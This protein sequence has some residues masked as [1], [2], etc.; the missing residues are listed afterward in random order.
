[1]SIRNGPMALG[2]MAALGL[3]ACGGGGGGATSSG[4]PQGQPPSSSGA[5]SQTAARSYQLGSAAGSYDL[6]PLGGFSGSLG[7]PATTVPANTRL[8]LTSSFQAPAGAAILQGKG[9]RPQDTGTL[10]VYF[11]TTIRLSSTVTFP[12]LPGFSVTLPATVNPTGLQFFY[13]ISN[14]TPTNGAEAQFRTEG[15]ATLSGQ[16][17]T[18]AP[19]T[20]PLTLQAGQP[21][22]IAFYAISAIAATPTPAPPGAASS[23]TES[24]LYSFRGGADGAGPLAALILDRQDRLYG[25]TYSG[26]SQQCGTVF[27]LTPSAPGRTAWTESVLHDFKAVPDG[28]NPAAGLFADASGGLYGTTKNGGAYG[29]PQ[30]GAAGGSGSV[31][32]LT[33]GNG[34]WSESVLFNFP[35]G[36]GGQGENCCGWAPSAGLIGNRRGDLYSTTQYGGAPGFEGGW[37][38]VFELAPPARG[39]SD[40]TQSVLYAFSGSIGDDG[41]PQAALVL[42]GSG[43]L[44]GTTAGAG[45]P[46]TVFELTPLPGNAGWSKSVIHAFTGGADGAGPLAGLI[47]DGR[48][49]LCGTTQNGGA[50]G[51]GSVFALTTGN[52]GWSESVLYSF[53]AGADGA[54]PV[55]GL[56]LDRRGTLYGTT[57]GGG[58]HS[59]GTVFALTPPV[60]GKTAWTERVLYAFMGH[61]D[62]CVPHAAL[63]A[64]DSFALYGTTQTGGAHGLGTVFKLTPR[65]SAAE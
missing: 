36:Y 25:T 16:I 40:W 47:F 35:P 4:L 32:A 63:V 11:Y 39:K 1:M 65:V 7:L 12:T 43:N 10:N 56:V 42:D 9:L 13:A 57:S 8:D 46:G 33:P 26:G 28:C 48:G 61:A 30:T 62:G 64:D 44:Y 14:P 22:T 6:P 19:S 3:S 24:V 59:C 49:T 52:G 45:T 34:G 31:F 41:D 58:A 20:T 38:V 29:G 50:H 18:F 53:T 54:G 37:G 60:A 27:A 55:A 2:V 21:Y 51:W 5:T 15:P 23:W 17:V